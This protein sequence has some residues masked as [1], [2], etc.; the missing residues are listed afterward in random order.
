MGTNTFAFFQYR[1]FLLLQTN[2]MKTVAFFFVAA[3]SAAL[4]SDVVLDI[5]L[6]K[7]DQI[8]I[9]EPGRA[10]AGS[11]SFVDSDGKDHTVKYIADE[12]GYRGGWYSYLHQACPRRGSTLS[13]YSIH[14]SSSLKLPSSVCSSWSLAISRFQI[15]VQRIEI[16]IAAIGRRVLQERLGAL[17]PPQC[18]VRSSEMI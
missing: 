9:G 13:I 12:K 3:L 18:C 17:I 8:Q 11:Y 10:V 15:R 14:S 16:R 5:D 6:D 2:M 4:A 1:L 7:Q